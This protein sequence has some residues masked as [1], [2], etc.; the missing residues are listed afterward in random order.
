MKRRTFLV[1]VAAGCL[2]TGFAAAC[3]HVVT[4]EE[5][6]ASLVRDVALPDCRALEGASAG[7]S[8]HIKRWASAPDDAAFSELRASWKQTLLAWK[9]AYAFRNGPLVESNALLRAMFWPVRGQAIDALIA[10]SG[11][12]DAA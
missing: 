12:L 11:P 10:G 6:L 1:R 4:R 8:Q 9:R 5:V 3:E 2:V 7:L